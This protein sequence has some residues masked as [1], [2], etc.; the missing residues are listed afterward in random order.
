MLSQMSWE[1]YELRH[2]NKLSTSPA[3]FS[4]ISGDNHLCI[5][6]RYWKNSDQR[7]T[8]GGKK[9]KTKKKEFVIYQTKVNFFFLLPN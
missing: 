1:I 7:Q 5:Q 2:L 9:E 3:H 6:R 8:E 4:G